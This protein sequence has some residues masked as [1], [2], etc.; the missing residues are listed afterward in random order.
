V[1]GIQ[2]IVR[3]AGRGSIAHALRQ[4]AE[5]LARHQVRDHFGPAARL[6]PIHQHERQPAGGSLDHL[7]RVARLAHGP[8]RNLGNRDLNFHSSE[9]YKRMAGEANR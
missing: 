4:Q 3:G 6:L 1:Q 2:V 8:L 9:S 5:R 7:E